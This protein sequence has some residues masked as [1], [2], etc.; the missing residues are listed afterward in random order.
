MFG[1]GVGQRLQGFQLVVSLQMNKLKK[2]SLPLLCSQVVP[3][4]IG[5]A[6]SFNTSTK[7]VIMKCLVRI[8]IVE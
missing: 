5:E 1:R 2:I 8:I 3:G 7:H 6:A 4:H